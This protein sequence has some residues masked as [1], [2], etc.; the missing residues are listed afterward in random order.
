MGARPALPLA[1]TNTTALRGSTRALE[2]DGGAC[3]TRMSKRIP[4]T[5]GC[6]KQDRKLCAHHD[7]LLGRNDHAAVTYGNWA[8][9]DKPQFAPVGAGSNPALARA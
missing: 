5:W 3:A 1:S 6:N 9:R 4:P 7:E 8:G 2:H